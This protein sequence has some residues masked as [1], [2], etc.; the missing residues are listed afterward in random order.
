MIL[1]DDYAIDIA[2]KESMAF[3]SDITDNPIERGADIT[4]HVQPKQPVL[5]FE[6]VVSDTPTG[7]VAVHESRLALGETRAS[8]DA[9]RRFTKLHAD[10][11]VVT[12][13]CSFGRFDNMV[14]RD[15][16]PDK[17][18]QSHKGLRFTAVFR[19]LEIVDNQRSTVRVA[20]PNCGKK[21]DFGLSLDKITNGAAMLWRKGRPPG[22]SPST[23]PAGVIYGQEVVH[24]IK[25]HFYHEDKRRQLS[26]QELNDFVKDR[27]RD[28]KLSL[29]RSFSRADAKVA[30]IQDR[31]DRA[32]ALLR[33][34]EQNP[35]KYI[36]PAL[37]GLKKSGN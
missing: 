29:N 19:R 33:A 30:S 2:L 16:T 25:G 20:S 18:A 3:A 5:T 11:Q 7:R 10:A 15:F 34:K 31:L 22:T 36:D 6:S 37:F 35:G 28:A 21:Q 32:D 27:D 17:D 14:L 1:V 24:A 23:V 9:F 8:E 12:V 4:S 26:T 13:T